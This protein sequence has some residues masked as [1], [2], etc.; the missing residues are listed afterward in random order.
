MIAHLADA[1][2]INRL[3]NA[4]NRTKPRING[5]PVNPIDLRVSA[6][7]TARIVPRFVY[8]KYAIN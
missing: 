1:E 7:L 2:P 6:P 8:P 4:V 3:I 5:N